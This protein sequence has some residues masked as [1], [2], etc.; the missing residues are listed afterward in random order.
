MITNTDLSSYGSIIEDIEKLIDSLPVD[1]VL[2]R[3]GH[4]VVASNQ[5]AIDK[6][7]VPDIKCYKA[8]LNIDIPCDWCHAGEAMATNKVVDYIVHAGVDESGRVIDL[9]TGGIVSDSHWIPV[10]SDLYIHFSGINLTDPE[11]QKKAIADI[12]SFLEKLPSE[13]GQDAV[14]TVKTIN[15][16]FKEQMEN[17]NLM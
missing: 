5:L 4:D 6:G 9:D 11:T 8:W 1:A 16:A 7:V 10:A 3:K 2:I 12:S 13:I 17:L 15:D 14:K